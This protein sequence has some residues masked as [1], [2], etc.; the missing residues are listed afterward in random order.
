[1]DP[2]ALDA[3]DPVHHG[4]T[5]DP[6]VLD[7]SAN[8]NPEMPAGVAAVYEDALAAA[9]RYPDDDYP[10][11][12]AAAADYVD[13]NA[14]DVVPTAGAAS[15]LR[16]AVALAVDPGDTALLPAPGFSEYAHEV[17][18]RGGEPAFVAPDRLLAADPGPHALAIVCTPHN[19]TGEAYEVE[20]LRAFAAECRAADTLLVVDEA[21]LE[22]TDRPSLAGEPGVVVLRSLTKAFG[23]P[24]L[25]A[26][27]LVAAGRLRDRLATARLS[28]ELSAPAAAVGAHCLRRTGF[29]ERTRDRVATERDRM[30]ER[31]AARYDVHD[32]EAPFLLFEAGA[33]GADAV[34]ERA[35]EAG[36]AV[37]D[38]RT[39]RR[40]DD[41]VRVAVRRPAENDR[42]LGALD[43]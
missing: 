23:L 6:D 19:P 7:F 30:R 28:W 11:F 39:F 12:R 18:L 29:V 1:M 38:A 34:I 36:I 27:F 17:A 26:G 16:L 25:R 33:E 22:F 14:A 10:A 3:A 8:T 2:D 40:L 35:R 20:A 4:G 43:V 32:S 31:L 37:R 9:R 13:C 15:A 41:H 24:G 42:L 5:T 21:F